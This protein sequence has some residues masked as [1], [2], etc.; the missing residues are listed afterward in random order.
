MAKEENNSTGGEY[1]FDEELLFDAI[2][3]K[4]SQMDIETL[5][6]VKKNLEKNKEDTELIDKVI[7]RKVG[8]KEEDHLTLGEILYGSFLGLKDHKKRKSTISSIYNPEEYAKKDGYYDEN[9]EEEEQEEDD[10][11]YDDLD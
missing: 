10:F 6:K 9:L 7:S 4:L 2:E 5:Q 11:Y 8:T 3:E 1:S